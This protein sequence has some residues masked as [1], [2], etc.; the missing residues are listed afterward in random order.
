MALTRKLYNEMARDRAKKHTWKSA[1]Q[2]VFGKEKTIYGKEYAKR[3]LPEETVWI[4]KFNRIEDL[5]SLLNEKTKLIIIDNLLLKSHFIKLYNFFSSGK[6][7]IESQ[8]YVFAKMIN[9]EVLLMAGFDDYRNPIPS[10]FISLEN[11]SY[12][13][14]NLPF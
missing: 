4:K 2:M 3:F 11:V 14:L 6:I 8:E 13:D 5:D 7:L 9:V 12:E 10:D 1:I